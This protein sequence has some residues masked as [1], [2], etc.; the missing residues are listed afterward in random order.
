MDIVNLKRQRTTLV[1]ETSK[2]EKELELLQEEFDEIT[3]NGVEFDSSEQV[4]QVMKQVL[5]NQ[6]P[7]LSGSEE[8][9]KEA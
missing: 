3:K 4:L 1:T 2:V 9:E 6:M 5:S 8:I 7:P